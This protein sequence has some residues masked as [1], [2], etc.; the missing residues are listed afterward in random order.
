MFHRALANIPQPDFFNTQNDV[1]A[2]AD[3][4]AWGKLPLPNFELTNE[5]L[6]KIFGLLQKNTLSN[7]LIHGDWGLGNILFSD[8]Y[9]PAVIDFSPYFRPADFAPAIMIIDALAYEDADKS[10]IDLY[11]S[12]PNYQQLFLRALARRICEYIGHQTHPEN[13]KDFSPD[14]IKYLNL[15]DIILNA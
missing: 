11:K 9:P 8:H 7:Q 1:W 6:Q 13:I 4:I 15:L 3:K 2:I 10:I 12:I 14:I 5:P